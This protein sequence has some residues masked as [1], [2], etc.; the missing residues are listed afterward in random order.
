MFTF[1]LVSELLMFGKKKWISK[2]D[3]MTWMLKAVKIDLILCSLSWLQYFPIY[4]IIIFFYQPEINHLK[5]GHIK[6]FSGSLV[7]LGVCLIF[8]YIYIVLID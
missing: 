6:T 8:T 3:D 7:I 4:F 5:S 1:T 2:F